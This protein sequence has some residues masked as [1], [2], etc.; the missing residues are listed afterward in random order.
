[1]IVPIFGLE[2][3]I[4]A[5]VAALAVG[6]FLYLH[7]EDVIRDSIVFPLIT[8]LAVLVFSFVLVALWTPPVPAKARI[9]DY[10]WSAGAATT[11]LQRPGVWVTSASTNFGGVVYFQIQPS[12]SAVCTTVPVITGQ[13][14]TTDVSAR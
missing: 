9:G 3:S 10:L 2:N 1:M 14:S 4:V 11:L 6:G 8:L 5:L 13:G 12:S 7:Y